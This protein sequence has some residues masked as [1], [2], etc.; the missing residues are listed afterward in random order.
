MAVLR[1]K[2]DWNVVFV[3]MAPPE[4]AEKFRLKMESPHRFVC[5]PG[6]QL[7][8]VFGLKRG[9]LVQLFGPNVWRAGVRAGKHGVGVPVGDPLQLSG[10]FVLNSSGE[11]TWEHRDRDAGDTAPVDS[12]GQALGEG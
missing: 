3:C 2:A 7:Y 12:I 1:E 11:V 5:D 9:S 6:K 8:E 10:T 4:E